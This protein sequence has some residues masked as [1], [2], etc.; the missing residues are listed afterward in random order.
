MEKHLDFFA[1]TTERTSPALLETPRALTPRLKSPQLKRK[2]SAK[3]HPKNE[4]EKEKTNTGAKGNWKKVFAVRKFL[5][6]AKTQS[7]ENPAQLE[8]AGRYAI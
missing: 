2:P 1:G 4:T 3:P 5:T 8:I 7:S 6:L